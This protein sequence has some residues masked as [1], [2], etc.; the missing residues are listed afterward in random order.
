MVIS[1]SWASNLGVLERGPCLVEPACVGGEDAQRP[2]ED[3]ERVKHF[4]S[5]YENLVLGRSDRNQAIEAKRED[6]SSNKD[7]G[8]WKGNRL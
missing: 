6:R 5:R 3:L 4:D 7:E 8:K 2:G 1:L